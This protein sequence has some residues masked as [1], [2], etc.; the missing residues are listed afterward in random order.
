[1]VSLYYKTGIESCTVA[2][3]RFPDL[4]EE[5]AY[6][7]SWCPEH[8]EVRRCGKPKADGSKLTAPKGAL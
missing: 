2:T 3:T 4:K 6:A 8:E 1:M 5:V 7:A